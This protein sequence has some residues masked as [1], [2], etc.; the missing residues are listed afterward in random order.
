MAVTRIDMTTREPLLGGQHFG[1]TG[2]YEV[3]H[4]TVTL[5]VDPAHP[6]QRD[7]TDLDK[8][9]RTA[10]GK[11]EWWADFA[12]LQPAD[13]RRGNRRLFFEV[14]NRGRMRAF[15]YF[16]AVRETP[17]LTRAEHIGNGFWLFG[18]SRCS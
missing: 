14:V 15:G 4:G 13:P 17:N 10:A 9:P 5:A 2:A 7:I 16:D 1:A 8:A 3:L 11:V 6:R 12:L 18:I